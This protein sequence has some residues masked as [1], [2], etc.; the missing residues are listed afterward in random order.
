MLT[1]NPNA[2]WEIY[3]ENKEHDNFFSESFKDLVTK[4]LRL[5]PLNRLPID[6]IINHD[7][8]AEK[9]ATDAEVK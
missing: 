2:F 3:P 4:M 7:W 1:E 5:D 8:F 9:I 6:E